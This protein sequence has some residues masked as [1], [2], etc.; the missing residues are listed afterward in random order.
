MSCCAHLYSYSLRDAALHFWP[1]T[2]LSISQT[3]AF[4]LTIKHKENW[5]GLFIKQTVWKE[6]VHK[7][8]CMKGAHW[9][10][11]ADKMFLKLQFPLRNWRFSRIPALSLW[12]G[13]Y[14][15]WLFSKPFNTPLHS[16]IMGQVGK[17]S[18]NRQWACENTET[19]TFAYNFWCKLQT[20]THGQSCIYANQP[21]EGN[22]FFKMMSI[23]TQDDT[24]HIEQCE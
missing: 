9:K 24:E 16:D 19:N 7:T 2:H 17:S 5:R 3:V 21:R 1:H 11:L 14:C 13:I 23:F 8:N 4:Q 15:T 22:S 18:N 20:K 6:L 10:P 12:A